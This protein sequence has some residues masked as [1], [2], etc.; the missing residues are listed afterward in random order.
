MT[1]EPVAATGTTDTSAPAQATTPEQQAPETPAAITP[2]SEADSGARGDARLAPDGLASP[3]GDKTEPPDWPDDWRD[4]FL[5][6][7]KPD[8]RE[9]LG[10]RLN[11]FTSP[12]NV[13]S[14]YLELERKQSS[15]ALKPALADDAAPEDVEAYRKAWGVPES[16]DGY[17][18][19]FPEGLEASDSDKADLAEFAKV[20]HGMNAP[21]HVVK[22]MAETYFAMQ[23]RAMQDMYD[24]AHNQ[25]INHTA[26]L[27]AEYGRD[28]TRNVNIAKGYLAST[29]GA[30]GADDLVSLTLA[31]GTKLGDNPLFV[32]LAVSSG[33]ATADDE[34]LVT[35]D[36]NTGGKTLEDQWRESLDLAGTDPKKFHSEEHQKRHMMLGKAI[37]A[38]RNKAA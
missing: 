28:F 4:R 10:K 32:R 13:L 31:D 21:P 27:K 1:D 5:R 29:V 25:T 34:A 3:D 14:S 9:K 11:R 33:L 8:E 17:G 7:A 19:T 23:E 6:K 26:E 36:L 20:A 18:L 16:P 38:R 35:S 24:A 30:V 2:A 12:D 22:G 37:A 15:G